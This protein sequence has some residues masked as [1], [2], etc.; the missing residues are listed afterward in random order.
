ML[1]FTRSALESLQRFFGKPCHGLL[2]AFGG[3]IGRFEKSSFTKNV[4]EYEIFVQLF[5]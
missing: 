5:K 4:Q 2:M 1:P 3:A